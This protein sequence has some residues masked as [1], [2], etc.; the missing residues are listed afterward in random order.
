MLFKPNILRTNTA[1]RFTADASIQKT[2]SNLS[3]GTFQREAHPQENEEKTMRAD[4]NNAKV[5]RDSAEENKTYKKIIKKLISISRF[6]HHANNN[7]ERNKLKRRTMT[8]ICERTGLLTVESRKNQDHVFQVP[9]TCIMVSMHENIDWSG[10]TYK[11][12]KIVYTFYW[13]THYPN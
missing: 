9:A 10:S 5:E 11:A 8:I 4:N 13:I 7:Y 2:Y 12:D 6:V 1:L 3:E